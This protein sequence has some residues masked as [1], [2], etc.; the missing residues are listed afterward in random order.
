MR[1]LVRGQLALNFI[2]SRPNCASGWRMVIKR[3]QSIR[4]GNALN[5]ELLCGL[6]FYIGCHKH[7]G[8]STWFCAM[9]STTQ[10][11]AI[12]TGVSHI[13]IDRC[14]KGD[15]F[16]WTTSDQQL[17]YVNR[18]ACIPAPAAQNADSLRHSVFKFYSSTFDQNLCIILRLSKWR[19]YW[20]KLHHSSMTGFDP[21]VN[22]DG[23]KSCSGSHH[24]PGSIYHLL[25]FTRRWEQ[26][27]DDFAQ[28]QILNQLN[29]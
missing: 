24:V 28:K 3:V 27:A 7:F 4:F 2:K 20:G 29:I 14:T 10:Y 18:Y 26:A 19:F 17:N 12:E 22:T 16:Y 9:L 23:S 15:L 25:S 11:T 13:Q 5:S 21:N 1:L 8:K 6:S